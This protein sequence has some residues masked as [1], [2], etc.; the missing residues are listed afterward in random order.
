MLQW[1]NAGNVLW[2]QNA[3]KLRQWFFFGGGGLVREGRDTSLKM[4]L[5]LL[6]NRYICAIYRQFWTLLCKKQNKKTHPIQ[7]RPFLFHC[8]IAKYKGRAQGGNPRSAALII[9]KAQR[10]LVTSWRGA[11]SETWLYRCV[12]CYLR[13][14]RFLNSPLSEARSSLRPALCDRE[15]QLMVNK[16]DLSP[17]PG[18][19]IR[20]CYTVR[21]WKGSRTDTELCGNTDLCVCVFVFC[22]ALVGVCVYRLVVSCFSF[23]SIRLSDMRWWLA[24]IVLKSLQHPLQEMLQTKDQ[25]W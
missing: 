22:V 1:R 5:F 19:L 7:P 15:V 12:W 13:L 4:S 9:T 23:L 3:S 17:S 18:T 14:S 10:A 24:V 2:Q 6:D 21:V 11:Q 25:A 20:Q 16:S 8:C